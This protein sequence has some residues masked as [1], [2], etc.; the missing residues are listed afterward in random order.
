MDAVS[1]ILR[2]DGGGNIGFGHVKRCLSLADAI[3]DRGG[4]P[5]IV[6]GTA[7]AQVRTHI[8]G[9]GHACRQ[10]D[11]AAGFDAD[12]IVPGTQ[13]AVFDFSHAATRARI[14]ETQTMF[15]KLH[16]RGVQTLLIDAKGTE[17][18]CAMRAMTVDILAIPYAGAENEPVLPGAATDVRGLSYF[19]LGGVYLGR[20][21]G[22]RR[23]PKR[24]ETILVTAGGSDPT[25]LTLLFLDA[26]ALLPDPLDVRVVIGPAFPP[27]RA[28]A[29]ADACRHLVHRTQLVEAPESLSDEMLRADVTLSASGLTKYEL[30]YSGN[31]A[32]LVSIDENHMAANRPF[33]ALGCALDM[34]LQAHVSAT[35]LADALQSLIEDGPRRQTMADAGPA[36]IDGHGTQ[37]LLDLLDA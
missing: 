36:A 26:L 31:P 7:D 9:A 16:D 35:A 24:A 30:A 20:H 6:L 11:D 18:L 15:G 2:T 1:H 32:I 12:A 10:L 17:C 3:R 13:R 34:G 14:D 8:D 23:V 28:A 19:V 37:R 25:D 5:E 4:Q 21:D 22:D 27:E 29:V 33:D